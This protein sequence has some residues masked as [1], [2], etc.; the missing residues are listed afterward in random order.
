M[1]FEPLEAIHRWRAAALGA[2]FMTV[3]IS[4]A[5]ALQARVGEERLRA[6]IETEAEFY[7][8]LLM[9]GS[10]EEALERTWPGLIEAAGSRARAR[11]F[12]RLQREALTRGN[13]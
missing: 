9:A 6:R 3:V 13:W 1:T 8:A 4:V 11:E 7:G 5:F 12:L 10:V 2:T